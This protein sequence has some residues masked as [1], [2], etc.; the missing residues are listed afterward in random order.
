M[1]TVH[2]QCTWFVC[3][4]IFRMTFTM[5]LSSLLFASRNYCLH[6]CSGVIEQPIIIYGSGSMFLL[7]GIQTLI[8]K[9]L[10]HIGSR[11]TLKSEHLKIYVQLFT[12]SFVTIFGFRWSLWVHIIKN[13]HPSFLLLWSPDLNEVP[14]HY[15]KKTNVNVQTSLITKMHP[16]D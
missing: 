3:N 12:I 14:E 11:W 13:F 1:L 6:D 5:Y 4:H 10:M 16:N 15:G 8:V 7:T 9:L 2:S